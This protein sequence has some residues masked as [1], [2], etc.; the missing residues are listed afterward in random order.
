M[1]PQ[2]DVW[3]LDVVNCLE[4][5]YTLGKSAKKKKGIKHVG[6][7]DAVLDLA[8]NRNFHHILASGSADK[9]L[10][11]WDIDKKEPNVTIHSFTDKVQSLEWHKF[12]AH[13]LIAGF[14]F[15]LSILFPIIKLDGQLYFRRM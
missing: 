14:I 2:I 3:D 12:E 1:E 5:A 4:P 15:N 11:L 10:M 8:W 9:K 13:L 7:K 6:H